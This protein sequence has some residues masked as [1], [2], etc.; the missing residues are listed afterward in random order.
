MIHVYVCI[1][2]N[3]CGNTKEYITRIPYLNYV[4][5]GVVH[6][7][8]VKTIIMIPRC[9]MNTILF[10]LDGTLLPMDVEEFTHRYFG[11]ILQTMN[12]KGFDGKMILDAILSSTKAMILNDGKKTNEEVF[13]ENFTSLTNLSR[14]LMEPHFNDFY[15]HVF[16]QIDSHVQSENMKQA[17]NILKEK[18]YRL[19][20]S[21][22][23]LF[24]RIATLKRIQW[25]GL[26]PHDFDYITT[27]ENSSACKPNLA[28][29]EE[30]I[31]KL[32]LDIKECM[33]VGN[34]VQEDGILEKIGIPVYL[35]NDYLLNRNNQ[36]ITTFDMTDSDAFLKYVQNLPSL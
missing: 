4:S 1:N 5:G 18:N 26:D 17:V 35:V 28:Y 20:L 16:D 7:S 29:Y 14:D 10:D 12:E 21:T 25:A 15:E 2:Q 30:I 11:L 13:W 19:I 33:M 6:T 23:P 27:Y 8:Y 36:K 32:D 34:D 3:P 31:D 9:T 22:N 24:P